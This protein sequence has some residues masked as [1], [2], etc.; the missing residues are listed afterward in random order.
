MRTDS[1]GRGYVNI[2]VADKL[3]E[4]A[5]ALRDVPAVALS[6]LFEQMPEVG[7]LDKPKLVFFSTRRISYS[8]TRPRRCWIGSSRSCG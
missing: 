5:A 8:T 2:L 1:D 3:M 4:N 6:E 7:D